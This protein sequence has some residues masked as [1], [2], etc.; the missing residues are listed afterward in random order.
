MK[1]LMIIGAALCCVMLT[2]CASKEEKLVEGFYKQLQAGDNDKL[3]EWAK[4]NVNK[5]F[6]DYAGKSDRKAK[7]IFA[8][9]KGSSTSVKTTV[10]K[11]L[12]DGKNTAKVISAECE[13]TTLYFVVGEIDGKGTQ[14][15]GWST[16]KARAMQGGN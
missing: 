13:G 12:K 1:K 15:I 9:L 4:K 3:D 16:D 2:G 8:A 11:E 14:I 7:K 5:E 10:I 6:F